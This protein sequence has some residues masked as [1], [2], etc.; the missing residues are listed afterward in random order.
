[1]GSYAVGRIRRPGTVVLTSSAVACS[2]AADETGAGEARPR[3]A[4]RVDPKG[5]AS[6]TPPSRPSCA[7]YTPRLTESSVLPTP[8][9]PPPTTMTRRPRGPAPPSN[10]GSGGKPEGGGG[11]VES[12][13]SD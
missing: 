8:P 4:C 5:S 10:G 13:R 7:K 12:Y 2:I 11:G 9:R 3:T 6:Q 1:M